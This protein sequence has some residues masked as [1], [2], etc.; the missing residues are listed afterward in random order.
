MVN[1]LENILT[2]NFT[3]ECFKDDILIS[4]VDDTLNTF[5]FVNRDDFT[6]LT[7]NDHI[8]VYYDD[9]KIDEELGLFLIKNNEDIVN[10]YCTEE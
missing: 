7:I 8:Y 2:K 10:I 1:Y 6:K 9:Y 3:L 4:R 5:K